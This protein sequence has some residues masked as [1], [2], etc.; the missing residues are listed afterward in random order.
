MKL[1]KDCK[2]CQLSERADMSRCL[3]P[4]AKTTRTSVITGEYVVTFKHYENQSIPND[5]LPFCDSMRSEHSFCG[6]E[7]S[8]FEDKK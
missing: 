4:I 1:C 6:I 3:H 5:F 7:A 2:H 8:L